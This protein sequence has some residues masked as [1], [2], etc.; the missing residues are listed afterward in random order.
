MFNEGSNGN[1]VRRLFGAA[2][3]V[4]TSESP[5]PPPFSP[6]E[7]PRRPT[8]M[9]A[10][11]LH[12]SPFLLLAVALMALAVLLVHD[13]QPA[14]A[15]TTT[16]SATLTVDE[17]SASQLFGCDSSDPNLDNCDTALTDD[18][19]T[20][21]GTAYDVRRVTWTSGSSLLVFDVAPSD[22]GQAPS[23][24]EIKTLFGSLTL[25][26]DGT[27]LAISDATVFTFHIGWT[28]TPATDWTDGQ[29]VSVSLTEP[30]APPTNLTV[31]AS[32]GTLSLSWTAPSSGTVTGYD[33]HYTS[34]T[35][36][37]DDDP[38]QGGGS[39]SGW[40]DPDYTGTGTTYTISGL[41]NGTTYRTRVR[42]TYAGGE[43]A[44]VHRSG[45]P[46]V[47]PD[48]TVS[49][50][51]SPNPVD[52]GSSVTIT[53]TLSAAQSGAVTIPITITDGTAEPEDHGTLTS[54]SI[55]AGATTG[56]GT[57]TT[58]Q[59][60][61]AANEVFTVALGTLPSGLR[62]GS[63]RSVPVTIV[64]DEGSGAVGQTIWTG[65]LN[66]QQ[67]RSDYLGCDRP[68][69][70]RTDGEPVARR[71]TDHVCETHLSPH[72]FS[73][74]GTTYEI[75]HVGLFSPQ[76]DFLQPQRLGLTVRPAIPEEWV[77][78]VNGD[79]WLSQ[80][81]WRHRFKVGQG[82]RPGY[83][84]ATL[85]IHIV[86]NGTRFDW[87][88]WRAG[89]PVSLSL[90][91]PRT[92]VPEVTLTA[93][94]STV[95]EGGTVTVTA[96]LSAAMTRDVTIPVDGMTVSGIDIAAGETSGTTFF[97]TVDDAD[98]LD[99]NNAR[100]NQWSPYQFDE[101]HR[102]TLLP[103]LPA[104]LLSAKDN[105]PAGQLS[106]KYVYVG[107]VDDDGDNWGKP[108][109]WLWCYNEHKRNWSVEGEEAKTT[110]GISRWVKGY[111]VIPLLYTSDYAAPLDYL[112]AEPEDYSGAASVA[113]TYPPGDA[114]DGVIT[115]PEDGDT[116]AAEAR[117]QVTVSID[118][119]ALPNWLLGG[120]NSCTHSIHDVTPNVGASSG[121]GGGSGSQDQGA[122]GQGQADY[123]DLIA[124]MKEWRDD[125]QW[126]SNKE[127][128][129][130]WDRA[131]LAFGET[132]ADT[133][134]T[135][136]TADEAQGYADRGWERWVE[137]AAALRDLESA[138]QQ[139]QPAQGQEPNRA[140]TVARA[141]P[142][143][144][145]TN[146]S[147]TLTVSLADALSD[148][149]NVF[150]DADGDRLALAAASSDRAVATAS[151]APGRHYSSS[152]TVR[153]QSRGTAVIT[154]T[155]DDGRGG[156]AE[157]SF[158][159]T[160]KAKPVVARRI[161]D[162]SGL[163][164]G[165]TQ[166]VSL[167]GVFRDADGDA[168]TL[169]V[170]S[171]D[172]DIAAV[173]AA[174]D[175]SAL[176]LRGAARGETGI[177]VR[178]GDTD[179]NWTGFQFQVE[180][181]PAGR[182]GALIARM[183]EWRNDPEWWRHKP[184]TDRWDRALLAFGETVEDTTLTPM[185]ADEAQGFAD[186]GWERW[187]EVA[188]ALREIES[189]APPEQ[190]N[191]A[192]TV[193]AAI[194]D[195]TIV[196][197]SGTQQ[198]SL[199]GVFSDADNDALTVTAVSSDDAVATV[200]VATDYATFSVNAQDRG[201]ATITVTADDG[202]GGTAEDAFTVTVKA[203]PDV[204]SA[205]ADVSGL[206]AG[207]TR[208]VS[209]A[210]VF[211]DADGDALTV[212][213]SSGD[214]A[215][216]TVSVAADHSALTVAGV[217][218]GTATV[219]V[220]AQDSDGNRVSDAFEV[221][222]VAPPPPAT[223]N[224]APTVASA[225]ADITIVSESGTQQVSLSG[226]FDDADGDALTVSAASSD[227]AIATVSV[228][229]GGS[230]LTVSARARGTATITVTANDGNGGTVEDTFTVKVKAAPTVSAA[231]ADVSGLEIGDTQEVSLAGVFSDGDGDRLT[232]SAVSSD[233]GI[234]MVSVASDGSRLT[235]S[236]VA[237]GTATITVTV[238][239][240]DGNRV[241]DAF[242]VAVAPEPEQDPPP[243][244]ETPNG[245]PTVARPMAD[246][247]LE[248]LQWRQ[249]SLA[250]V[251]RDPDGD[252]LTFTVVSSDYGVA[253]MWV[254]G[255]TLTVVA[256]S[257]GTATITVTAEDPDGNEVSDSFEVTVRP[258]S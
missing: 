165:D 3:H 51:A 38:A 32:S 173:S 138:G 40:W 48:D 153:A 243:D 219:T 17:Y 171:Q 246:I 67:I 239:D 197:A 41:T 20:Y 71:I 210:G 102:L 252:E 251:F 131:L 216:A 79:T 194:S 98:H 53:A 227:E 256:T 5:P 201:T 190:P 24:E 9:R 137:V 111:T 257:T 200:S 179:G 238:Q 146:E 229:S 214:E 64:D 11:V 184:H 104:G 121:Q 218:E 169:Q 69:H 249:F 88:N 221:S 73:H 167:A 132:V 116:G 193:A 255:S 122:V 240:S 80:R 68:V 56:T 258:A 236:G 223:P 117:E 128:T 226:V 140:P 54:I 36:V 26:V 149:P 150:K 136:M 187:I 44:W 100:I 152:L 248:E 168:L 130:R 57:I 114:Q 99:E 170:S 157:E 125:P 101:T 147:E 158:T 222:V 141:L 166:E 105:P 82:D 61:D 70:H 103:G 118:G 178:V 94:P 108:E 19:F 155:A 192:P 177:V 1:R 92:D 180:V 87:D 30:P 124:R 13:S 225:L 10:S 129:D 89:G 211:S 6:P 161:A 235:L 207:D 16:W 96:N 23:A 186:Q 142:D 234:A 8:M 247:S 90:V 76:P 63:P 162:I 133:S 112:N 119:S 182:H 12:R 154:V 4:L 198:V 43:S 253:S 159:V 202:N 81:D 199:S 14:Q 75:Y 72:T 110:V 151:V 55:T 191:R 232:I 18:D 37:G 220:T 106:P 233:A 139:A 203:A 58:A 156:T 123:A 183:Y 62:A 85:P 213:A 47:V 60:A 217:A 172:P 45:T 28:Y 31:T 52:E 241:S 91:V 21:N 97:T 160:V 93:S 113:L 163:A 22:G 231:I 35:T 204:A 254:S 189:G 245:S 95:L 208:D 175:G 230:S 148:R 188:A 143:R 134:L 242:E 25:N 135:P 237:E 65:A 66:V 59:D 215:I 228:A 164:A 144:R 250:D 2:R 50:S 209:L 126:S 195:A 29:S 206:E 176:T 77:L 49:L 145:I 181:I 174:A 224:Q 74:G 27:A 15:Q 34:S 196:S 212:T 107:V 7:N 115:F 185:T 42:A 78:V 84:D 33:V 120:G 127:H 86:W 244:G 109:V 39:A 83:T 205:I 46:A